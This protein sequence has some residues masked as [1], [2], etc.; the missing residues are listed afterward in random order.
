VRLATTRS[1]AAPSDRLLTSA[2]AVLDRRLARDG[3]APIAVAVS[4]GGD[5]RALLL[6]AHAWAQAAGRRLLVLTV[7]HRLQAA[8]AGWSAACAALA[9]GLG[10]GFQPLAWEGPKPA[11]GLPAAA[12]AARH[13]LLAEAARQA[14]A[15]VVLM[16]HTADDLLEARA[17]R[18][19]G[20]TTPDPREWAP[21]PAW[22]EG[23]GVFLLR[24]LLGLR[25]AELR[26]WLDARGEGWI[27][28]P[29]NEDPRYARV[30]ARALVAVSPE[31]VAPPPDPST[32]LPLDFVAGC[33]EDPGGGL[34]LPRATLRA[35]GDARLQRFL[36]LACVCAGGGDRRPA[37]EGLRRLAAQL[38]AEAPVVATLAGARIEA[39]AE[40]V[41]I[42]REA[43]DAARGGLASRRLEADVPTIWD[44]RF[45]LRTSRPDLEVR[46]LAGLARR[47]P[48]GQQRALVRLH[49]RSRLALPALVGPDGE[50]G[51]PVLE[52]GEASARSLVLERL[53][54]AAGLVTREPA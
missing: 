2:T 27:D 36:A 42:L 44:G 25:R 45:E 30:R 38:S 37:T 24:P 10:A 3:A 28:D 26:A 4:G 22:P 43:G 53:S 48:P 20:S 33:Q 50:I 46:R 12:R 8:S 35:V 1:P 51:C 14:G 7:D 40:R 15:H 47:L 52:R 49:P 41:A 32:D 13:R 17:M 6:I 9:A 29:A 11:R 31:R 19:A 5:S 54:A 23:R 21:S 18:A 16:G 34:S 39:D